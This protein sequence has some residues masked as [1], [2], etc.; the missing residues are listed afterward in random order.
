MHNYYLD[1]LKSFK[2]FMADTFPEI[3]HYQFNYADKSFLNYK[4]YQE[5]VKEFPICH[6]NLSDIRVDDNKAFMRQVGNAYNDDTIQPLCANHDLKDSVI[7]DFKWVI[8]TMQVKINLNSPSDVFNYHNTVLTHF[9]K[10]MMFYSYDYSSYID[11]DAWTKQWTLDHDTEGLYYRATDEITRAFALYTNSPLF[12]INGITKNKAI[13][14]D[15]SIDI[16]FEI[17]LKVPN[18]IGNKSINNM[19]VEG[20]QIVVNQTADSGMPILIDMNNDI[21]SDRRKKMRRLYILEEDDFNIDNN[22][23]ILPLSILPALQNQNLGVYMVSDNT[24][25]NPDVFWHE[26]GILSSAEIFDDRIEF[27]LTD[28]LKK[29]RFSEFSVLELLVFAID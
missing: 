17:H 27:K 25:G 24:I 11:V 19:I 13:E 6:I 26:Q 20:I 29:F 18:I 9:P 23:L 3:E 28:D 16:D 14:G 12:K 4:L 15:S 2:K 7:M 1:F 8:L 22:T 5:H 21:Y 10:N